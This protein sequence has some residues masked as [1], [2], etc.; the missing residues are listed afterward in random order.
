MKKYNYYID[1]SY[2]T[3][4]SRLLFGEFSEFLSEAEKNHLIHIFNV[5]KYNDLVLYC[6]PGWF[7]YNK[8]VKSLKKHKIPFA[9]Y[10]IGSF[11]KKGLIIECRYV[12][13]IE[14]VLFELWP[15]YRL[16]FKVKVDQTPES[17]DELKLCSDCID[18][19]SIDIKLLDYNDII[20]LVFYHG[21]FIEIVSK[22]NIYDQIIKKL[23]ADD[24]VILESCSIEKF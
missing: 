5:L 22:K 14:Y 24:E 11:F 8:V 13:V 10:R 6:E 17:L 1:K 9:E 15:W 3:S 4:Y 7:R 2:Y 12:D 21:S 16:L 19:R 18:G 20:L 23:S